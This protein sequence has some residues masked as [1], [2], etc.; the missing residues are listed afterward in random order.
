VRVLE[1]RLTWS[2]SRGETL[3]HCAR[4]Y[5]WTYYGS[6]G[7]WAHDAPAEARE[8]YVLKNLH[9]RW[10]WVGDAVHRAIERVLR[11]L[12]R[13]AVP[14][15]GLDLRDETQ[16]GN[17][18]RE[19]DVEAVLRAV[20]DSMRAQ[21]VDSRDGR[22]RADPKRVVGLVEHEYAAPVP[23][24][25]WREMNRR[26]LDAVRRFLESETFARI[27]DSDPATWLPFETLDSFDFEGTPVWAALD[28]AR[29]TEDGGA[30]VYDWKTGEDRPDANRLQ[31]LCYA[32]FLEARHGVPATRVVG[33]LFYVSTGTVA[34]VRTTAEELDEAR[35]AIRASI[36]EMRRRLAAGSSGSADPSKLAFPM[37]DAA[38]RCPVC[39]FRRLCGR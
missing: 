19:V 23:A 9:S 25:E 22:Y 30:E 18:G 29:R 32:M 8:A 20:T 4:K 14:D 39:A 7:G 31:M 35:A 36:A 33:R 28:F 21:Y 16:A 24:S 13:R 11:G 1:N 12:E 3:E 37:T 15:G 27:R 38:E 26:A 6:W 17:G 5:W 10:T 34:E 2:K